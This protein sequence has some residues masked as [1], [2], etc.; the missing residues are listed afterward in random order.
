MILVC[1]ILGL[2]KLSM[3]RIY[4]D[5]LTRNYSSA[6]SDYLA[7][8]TEEKRT[9]MRRHAFMGRIIFCCV[10]IFGYIVS[11]GLMVAPILASNKN[12]QTNISIDDYSPGYPIP[13]TCTLG[14]FHF[15]T[16][17][18][19]MIFVAEC[20]LIATVGAGNLGNKIIKLLD[21]NIIVI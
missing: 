8:D 10:V 2:L 5:N 16:K 6:V 15:S 21:S 17:L 14:H 11:L 20:I 9:I 3:Y 12:V 19:L 1:T 4:A 7:I 18:Y 13:A